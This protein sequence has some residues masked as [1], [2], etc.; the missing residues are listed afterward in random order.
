[1]FDMGRVPTFCLSER[2][3]KLWYAG[4][5][6]EFGIEP[7]Q[8]AELIAAQ[9]K[10]REEKARAKRAEEKLQEQRAERKRK[11]ES[12]R[13][14]GS[15]DFSRASTTS[16]IDLNDSVMN[17]KFSAA[18]LHSEGDVNLNGGMEFK[19]AV[20]LENARIAGTFDMS[21]SR[22]AGQ[23]SLVGAKVGGSLI[24]GF[25]RFEQSLV[26]GAMDVG[27]HLVMGLSR[28]ADAN[29]SGSKI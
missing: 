7:E 25:A 14:D 19:D 27:G 5:A 6:K 23:V 18:G 15:F 4:K 3:G 12:S 9:I 29:F 24:L 26:A 17:G 21:S 20:T 13:I 28:F 22:Y 10:D 11:T 2:N 1:M 16:L 8:F